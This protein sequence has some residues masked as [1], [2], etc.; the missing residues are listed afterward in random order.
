MKE[1]KIAR[2]ARM[3]VPVNSFIKNV[4][5]SVCV[6]LL[7]FTTSS[8]S[9]GNCDTICSTDE[10]SLNCGNESYAINLTCYKCQNSGDAQAC[11]G[12]GGPSC[13]YDQDPGQTVY[14]RECDQ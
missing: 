6:A 13:C 2:G 3:I 7:L 8:F 12:S 10:S 11:P 14:Y 4:R 9:C 1:S 5:A